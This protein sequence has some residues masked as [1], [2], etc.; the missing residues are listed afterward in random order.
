MSCYADYELV[1]EELTKILTQYRESPKLLFLIRSYLRK[2]EEGVQCIEDV[3]L[4]FDI[5]T[6]VGDQ[7]TILG[8][9][10]GWPRCHCVCEGTPVFGFEC[11]GVIEDYPLAGFCDANSTWAGCDEMGNA[12]ICIGDDELYRKFLK[13]RRY[14]TLAKFD[15]KSLRNCL[16]E[17]FGGDVAILDAKNGRILIAPG[18]ELTA[19][20]QLVLPLYPRVLPIAPSIEVRFYFGNLPVFGFGQGFVGFCADATIEFTDLADTDGAYLMNEDIEILT[21]QMLVTLGTAGNWA[22]GVDVH[23]YDCPTY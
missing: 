11:E 4:Y 13:V 21:E 22:C 20:E 5:D 9:Q 7:L 17:F 6:A 2:F 12:T 10:L 19:I 8:K 15:R 3:P 23:P 1:D 18:R 16:V 14:Q